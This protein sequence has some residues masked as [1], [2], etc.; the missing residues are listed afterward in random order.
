MREL[1]KENR[2]LWKLDRAGVL[3]EINANFRSHVKKSAA[4]FE[5][6]DFD[7]SNEGEDEKARIT[8]ERYVRCFVSAHTHRH[9]HTHAQAHAHAHT[10]TLTHMHAHAHVLT[11]AHVHTH[12][13]THKHIHVYT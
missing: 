8:Q 12:T 7:Y 1:H 5:F 13:H 4:L 3:E 9:T 2:L 6:V 11:H 10:R